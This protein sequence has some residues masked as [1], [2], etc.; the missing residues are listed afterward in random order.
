MIGIDSALRRASV[1][2]LAV[3]EKSGRVNGGAFTSAIITS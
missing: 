2:I 3:A 1:T